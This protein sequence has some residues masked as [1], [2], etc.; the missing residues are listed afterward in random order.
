MPSA[1]EPR[2]PL[3]VKICANTSLHDALAAAS[4]GA[5]A[6]GFVFAPSVR[7]IDPQQVRSI[8]AAL[9][10]GVQRVGVFPAASVEEIASAAHQANLNAVQLHGGGFNLE[11]T[12]ALEQRLGPSIALIHTLHWSVDSEADSATE[13]RTALAAIAQA[14]PPL[15]RV[16]VDARVGNS[17]SGGTGRS[18]DWQAAR[19]VF[20]SQPGL[21]IILAGGLTPANVAEAI[22]LTQPWGVDVASGV[23]RTHGIKDLEKVQAF[24]ENARHP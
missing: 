13:V 16:L 10:P 14:R 8:S 21:R 22:Q 18:F 9:P 1:P 24:I 20:A 19:T 15:S 7:R 11:L 3:W 5:D 17:N 4:L 2:P 12:K 23:E 6:V